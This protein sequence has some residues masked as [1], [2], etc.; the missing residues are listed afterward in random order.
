MHKRLFANTLLVEF[1]GS[2]LLSSCF[3]M[4][5]F[6]YTQQKGIEGRIS[7]YI[8]SQNTI[9][10]PIEVFYQNLSYQNKKDQLLHS[11]THYNTVIAKIA[12][13]VALAS[14]ASVPSLPLETIAVVAHTTMMMRRQQKP[15]ISKTRI[16]YAR[17]QRYSPLHKAYH[18]DALKE[19]L[20]VENYLLYT[21][22]K[23]IDNP[24]ERKNIF[25]M[26]SYILKVNPQLDFNYADTVARKIV[27]VARKYDLPFI[28]LGGLIGT[29][30]TYNKKAVSHVGATG[31][32]QVYPKV[33]KKTLIQKGLISSIQDLYTI[34]KNIEAGAYILNS[35]YTL[36]KEMNHSNPL[37]Y[38]LHRYYGARDN[39][40]VERVYKHSQ[41]IAQQIA[42]LG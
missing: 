32:T 23:G 33:W 10:T 37:R 21:L 5:L 31:L 11:I 38:A 22:E 18:N 41:R 28:L 1:V 29:E 40:Y 6:I 26:R 24:A 42:L 7:T 19:Y 34:E 3:V 4:T 35:Y 2:L 8:F 17:L 15:N 36:G 13:Q 25:A 39:S 30:S 16:N 12:R 14:F 27:E 20:L 9:P